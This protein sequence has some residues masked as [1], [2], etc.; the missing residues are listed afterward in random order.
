MKIVD[1]IAFRVFTAYGRSQQERM[2]DRR[3]FY[4]ALTNLNVKVPREKYQSLYTHLSLSIQG[5]KFDTSQE[6]DF[7]GSGQSMG[8]RMG[9]SSESFPSGRMSIM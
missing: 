8:S 5:S 1:C 6:E 3:S 2:L 7:S 4:M 9:G